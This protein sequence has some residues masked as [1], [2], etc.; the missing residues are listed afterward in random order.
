MKTE[1]LLDLERFFYAL[2]L[3]QYV[4]VRFADFF[5]NYSL[6]SDID[7]FCYDK[8]SVAEKILHVG[9]YYVAQGYEID[10][11]DVE[12]GHSQIDFMFGGELHIKFDL[13]QELPEFEKLVVLPQ[14]IYSVLENSENSKRKFSGNEYNFKT[15]SVVDD[16]ILRYI[17]YYEYS[18][19]R[20]DK[21]KHLKYVERLLSEK[22]KLHEIFI[23]K[24]N[25]YVTSNDLN[26]NLKRSFKQRLRYFMYVIF[27][28]P[29]L[30]FVLKALRR[31]WWFF[32]VLLRGK[33]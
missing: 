8:K 26:E 5:S 14:Y 19:I 13:Y 23:E 30:G 1:N 24:L 25:R 7:I 2:R 10:L 12:K 33:K 31:T 17:E 28:I 9:N 32:C 21:Q 22:P 15:P 6:N 3:E 20:P 11:Y 16:C 4:V 27:G 29:I 18:D